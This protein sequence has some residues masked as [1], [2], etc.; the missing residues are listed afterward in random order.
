[1]VGWLLGEEGAKI[2]GA[3]NDQIHEAGHYF[4]LDDTRLEELMEQ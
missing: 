1:M 2:I 3:E 4:V